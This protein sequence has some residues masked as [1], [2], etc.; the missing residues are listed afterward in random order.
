MKQITLIT[1]VIFS[2]FNCK[3]QSP[4][5]DMEINAK[6]DS[7]NNSYYKDVNNIL[8]TFEGTWLYVNGNTSLKI[9]L[10]KNTMFFNGDYYEDLMI[11]GYQ[12]IENGIEKIKRNHW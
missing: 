6:M 2:F 7:P 9:K 4:I 3:A 5:L 10:V 8:N 12:Y 1:I 11:G